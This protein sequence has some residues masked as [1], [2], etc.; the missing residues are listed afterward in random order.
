[1]HVVLALGAL[2]VGGAA[3]AGLPGSGALARLAGTA[4]L[5]AQVTLEPQQLLFFGAGANAYR[6]RGGGGLPGEPLDGGTAM[7]FSIGGELRHADRLL[8][9][10]RGDGDAAPYRQHLGFSV[11]GRVPLLPEGDWRPYLGGGVGMMWLQPALDFERALDREIVPR[12]EALGGLDWAGLPG[13]RIFAEYRLTGASYL[14]LGR[15]PGCAG[16]EAQCFVLSS[17]R[18]GHRGHAFWLGARLRVL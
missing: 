11:G 4:P 5:A 15:E 12:Y 8:L 17:G 16:P 6:P 14:A 2:L 18:V 7:L 9:Y 3:G 13:V 10:F 1:V